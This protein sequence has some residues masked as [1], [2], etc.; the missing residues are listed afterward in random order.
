MPVLGW[1]RFAAAQ[2]WIRKAG[3]EKNGPT[4]NARVN[5]SDAKRGMAALGPQQRNA[6]F[7]E[8]TDYRKRQT[9]AT[10]S[11]GVLDPRQRDAL[12]AE[13]VA[14]QKRQAHETNNTG[15]LDPR[16]RV[17]LFAASAN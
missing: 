2:E 15:V 11:A 9:H 16:R 5:D 12:F 14:Y 8:F 4:R 7:T 3:L 6:L 13:F 17:A 1:T 10:S